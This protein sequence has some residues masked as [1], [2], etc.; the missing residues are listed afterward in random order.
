MPAT[1][2]RLEALGT[3]LFLAVRRP[4]RLAPAVRLARQVV[5]D[6]DATC[7][8]FRDDSDLSRANRSPGRW[9]EVDPL[10][11]AATAVACEVAAHTGG[12]VNPLLGRTL[13]ELG[14]DRDFG[15]LL[16]LAPTALV[17][18]AAVGEVPETDAWRGIDLD[19]DGAIR[20]PAGAALDLGSTGK[21]WTAD[22]V[23]AAIEAE[24]G[25]P[26]LVSV[27]GDVRV[28]GDGVPWPVALSERPGDPVQEQVLVGP[29]GLATSSTLVRR[30]SHDRV[31]RHHIVDPRTGGPAE[32]VWRTVTATGSSCVAANA[33]STAAVVLGRDAPD[34]L[35][36]RR[37]SARLVGRHGD[38]CLTGGWP[39][40][41]QAMGA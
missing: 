2:A 16:P 13:I 18:P 35:D 4:A 25:E 23:A 7:S 36:E 31:A 1:H 30:W 9:V 41:A 34:W 40:A 33:A 12:L 6:V 14:Y 29:G 37:V 39:L 8:R 27:G 24:L 26:C 28:C 17:D 11:V 22:L 15:R 38:V 19:P 10:L 20:L 5:A 32:E 21:A 3:Y